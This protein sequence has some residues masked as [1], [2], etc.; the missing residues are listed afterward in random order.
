[1]RQPSLIP[2]PRNESDDVRFALSYEALKMKG[3]PISR[4]ILLRSLANS[5]INSSVSIT[6]GPKINTGAFPSKSTEL[7]TSSPMANEDACWDCLAV[8]A[9]KLKE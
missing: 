9:S 2:G 5:H 3:T 1:M 4:E 6:H 7:V 8:T